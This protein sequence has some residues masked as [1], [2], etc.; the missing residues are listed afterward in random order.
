[1]KLWHLL[2][3][4]AG[5]AFAFSLWTTSEATRAMLV[6]MVAGSGMVGATLFTILQLFQL[7]GAYGE[8]PSRKNMRRLLVRGT[9][10]MTGCSV[11]FSLL[12][13]MVFYL[14]WPTE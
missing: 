6:V 5:I 3:G 10:L 7:L 9:C 8:F 12:L 1:M 13:F 2:T 4:I 11:V 14:L